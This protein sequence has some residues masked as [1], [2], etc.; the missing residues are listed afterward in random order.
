V[1]DASASTTSSTATHVLRIAVAG[2]QWRDAAIVRAGATSLLLCALEAH[3]SAIHVFLLANAL[4]CRSTSL[5]AG[6]SAGADGR[7]HVSAG[8]VSGPTTA[9][10]C[11]WSVW[12]A[13]ARA[14]FALASTARA[15]LSFDLQ[16][17]SV[18]ARLIGGLVPNADGLA[19]RQRRVVDGCDCAAER[20][21]RHVCCRRVRRL[22]AACVV[23]G[24]ARVRA[25]AA[26]DARDARRRRRE[27]RRVRV[28]RRQRAA[29]RG[30]L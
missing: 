22:A 17:A 23:G 12:R 8:G 25:G 4:E 19:R 15:L 3:S 20:R 1:C 2:C 9:A 7:R 14:A 13:V 28:G 26:A 24:A 27:R 29:A 30:A 6:R 11:S 18:V 10:T 16:A 5:E 21:R